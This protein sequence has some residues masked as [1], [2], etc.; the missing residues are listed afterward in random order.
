MP[1]AVGSYYCA[2][3]GHALWHCGLR[4]I[5][6]RDVKP[7]NVLVSNGRRRTGDETSKDARATDDAASSWDSAK[8]AAASGDSLPKLPVAR[9]AALRTLARPGRKRANDVATD[10]APF[11]GHPAALLTPPPDV[12]SNA[13][14][15]GRVVLCDWGS[16]RDVV[17][18]AEEEAEV[19]AAAAA[20]AVGADGGLDQT[21][22]ARWSAGGNIGEKAVPSKGA[23]DADIRAR[24]SGPRPLSRPRARPRARRA[25]P[26]GKRRRRGAAGA[27]V[28]TAEYL[29]PEALLANGA[30]G[31]A[32]RRALYLGRCKP[33]LARE[34]HSSATVGVSM[35][36]PAGGQMA[37]APSADL[38]ADTDTSAAKGESEGQDGRSGRNILDAPRGAGPPA[39]M[40]A[41]GATLYAC[42][43]GASCF[44][45]QSPYISMRAIRAWGRGRARS[46]HSAFMRV[47]EGDHSMSGRPAHEEGV[48]CLPLPRWM[49]LHVQMAVLMCLRAQPDVR[50][51]GGP[52]HRW[53]LSGTVLADLANDLSTSLVHPQPGP[54]SGGD[55]GF[56]APEIQPHGHAAPDYSTIIRSIAAAAS[57]SARG[58]SRPDGSDPIE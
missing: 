58:G 23:G 13:R 25:Q 34:V 24:R 53:E 20:A 49:D 6:H 39:D 41:L 55:S 29:S 9:Q 45:R 12:A 38:T 48:C 47:I 8:R 37:H 10:A 57:A 5:A 26:P 17:A 30:K 15:V 18:E 22:R 16:S 3:L 36:G 40:F 2:Q 14:M 51:S 19:E 54:A 27:V 35:T 42:N 21:D 43:A 56:Q 4:G 44:R 11:S 33:S 50:A 46:E 31:D 28:G 1:P 32:G 52:L 7:E